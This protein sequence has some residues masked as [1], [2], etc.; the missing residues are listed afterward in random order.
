L[1]GTFTHE[2]VDAVTKVFRM[3]NSGGQHTLDQLEILPFFHYSIDMLFQVELDPSQCESLFYLL[4]SSK[5]TEISLGEFITFISILLHMKQESKSNPKFSQEFF[6]R[7]AHFSTR[8]A[9]KSIWDSAMQRVHAETYE[10]TW[11]SVLRS[12]NGVPGKSLTEK[13][14]ALFSH[15]DSDGTG[16]I[17]VEELG[18][19]LE[20]CG[21]L[22]N[23][24]QLKNFFQAIDAEGDGDISIEDF[25]KKIEAV[26]E[27]RKKKNEV[28]AAKELGYLQRKHSRFIAA[29]NSKDGTP[30][31][32]SMNKL[33]STSGSSSSSTNFD[34]PNKSGGGG[35][36]I[37]KEY[38]LDAPEPSQVSVN[39]K[40]EY[41]KLLREN[42]QLKKKIDVLMGVSQ[43][44]IKLDDEDDEEK[45][46]SSFGF[47]GKAPQVRKL[48]Q[49][50]PQPSLEEH[51]GTMFS[52]GIY[53]YACMFNKRVLFIWVHY[54]CLTDDHAQP[55]PLY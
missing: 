55:I 40:D 33:N 35:G 54:S 34:T 21:V 20:S 18:L 19:G 30:L 50:Q 9:N 27:E 22:L 15:F 12:I 2:R 44:E 39:Y 14:K 47:M 11:T 46:E 45:K 1:P 8:D 31:L 7:D 26:K 28:E 3:L 38:D 36:G 29:T 5:S 23:D 25:V 4:D 48:P 42:E 43:G 17:D 49:Q 13:V 10:N 32:S 16:H 24:S 6:G 37:P 52:G 41:V 53:M 51:F